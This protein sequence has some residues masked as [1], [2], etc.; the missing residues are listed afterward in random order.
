MLEYSNNIR[1]AKNFG[2]AKRRAP[3]RVGA[4]L[5]PVV[6]ADFSA[7]PQ[8]KNVDGKCQRWN[9]PAENMHGNGMNGN[10]LAVHWD[11]LRTSKR[12]QWMVDFLEQFI[13]DEV[14]SLRSAIGFLA[15][16]LSGGW[17]EAEALTAPRAP[18]GG[19]IG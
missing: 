19:S 8:P 1:L 11:A 17:M 15:G 7:S 12:S 14:A 6:A 10:A 18:E 5:L 4:A 13:F 9:L 2:S 16:L 3:R